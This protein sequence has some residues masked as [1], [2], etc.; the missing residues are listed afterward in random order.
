MIWGSNTDPEFS[1]CVS[2]NLISLSLHL[3]ICETG[4]N[5]YGLAAQY[6]AIILIPSLILCTKL[7]DVHFLLF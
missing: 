4:E 7:T 5:T 2:S 1:S 6:F 3:L